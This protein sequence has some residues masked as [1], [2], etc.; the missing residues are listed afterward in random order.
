M[1]SIIPDQPSTAEHTDPA[2]A[3]RAAYT[4]GL[5]ALADALDANPDLPLPWQGGPYMAMTLHFL[6]AQDPRAEMAAARRALGIPMDK[7][8]REDGYFDMRGTLHGVHIAFTAYRKDVCERVV[9]GTR[10]VE[11][12][13]PDPDAVAALPTVKRTEVI[14]D[15][16]WVCH[17]ILATDEPAGGAA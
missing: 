2:S 15:V 5:R 14:E 17:P 4:A 1:T 12:E 10:E 6:D 3:R 7:A 11:I 9:V 13:E 16:E 8:P